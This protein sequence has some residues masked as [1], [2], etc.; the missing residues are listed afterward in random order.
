M[1]ENVNQDNAE[2]FS[3]LLPLFNNKNNF[4]VGDFVRFSNDTDNQ[5]KPLSG[6]ILSIKG[7]F[8]TIFSYFYYVNFLK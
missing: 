5:Q 7:K 3:P 4:N 2:L 8:Y 1:V 6:V